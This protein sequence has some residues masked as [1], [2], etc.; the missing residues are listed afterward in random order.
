MDV[1]I[2]IKGTQTV[3][4]ESD[5]VE[6]TTAGTLEKLADGWKLCYSE[7]EVTGMNGTTTELHIQPQRVQLERTGSHP[8]MLILEKHRR[9]HCNYNTPYGTIDLGTYT[10]DLDCS[11]TEQGGALRFSYTLGFNGSVSS[12]HTVDITVQEDKNHVSDC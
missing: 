1:L 2:H 8:S 3:D 7:S 12:A 6:L 9:H 4:G 10:S 11:L 5:V